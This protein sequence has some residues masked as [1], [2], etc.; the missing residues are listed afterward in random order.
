MNKRK[1]LDVLIDDVLEEEKNNFRPGL[2][3]YE[4]YAEKIRQRISDSAEQFQKHYGQGFETIKS[5]LKQKGME[6]PQVSPQALAIIQ[7][8]TAFHDTLQG[9]QIINCLVSHQK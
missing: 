9:K 1:S 8:P 3:S 7:N 6:I 5:I 4:M 2:E